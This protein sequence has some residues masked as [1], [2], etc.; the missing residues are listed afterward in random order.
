MNQ[1]EA[2]GLHPETRSA[3]SMVVPLRLRFLGQFVLCLG[4]VMCL[5]ATSAHAAAVHPFLP[6][7]SLDGSTTPAGDFDKACGTAVDS[8]GNVY[9]SSAGNSTIEVFDPE[10][11]YLT[12]IADN[13]G[14]CSLAVDGKGNVYVVDSASGNVVKYAPNGGVYPPVAGTTYSF[15]K[16]IDSSGAA[17]AVAVNRETE[18]I[19]GV[20][21]D[22]ERVYVAKG[23]RVDRYQPDGTLGELEQQELTVR[24]EGG[25]FT[26]GFESET[27]PQ[28]PFN[29]TA[30]EVKA[31]LESL[32]AVGG[33]DVAVSAESTPFGGGVRMDYTVVFTGSLAS[34]DLGQIA[35]D[36]TGLVAGAFT[37][38]S[39]FI[40]GYDGRIGEGLVD[41]ASGV[42]IWEHNDTIYVADEDGVIYILDATG[43][44]VRAEIDG[45]GSPG[46]QFTALP[47][48]AIAVDQSNGHVFVSNVQERDVVEEYEAFGHYVT[49]LDRSFQDAGPT[50]IA[51][52]PQFDEVQFVHRDATGGTF[53]LSFEGQETAPLA[54][55]ASAKVVR[56]ALEAIPS[57]GGGGV[58]VEVATSTSFYGYRVA[59]VGAVG[60]RDVPSLG[61]DGAALTG[62]DPQAG[63][64]GPSISVTTLKDGAG[65]GRVY[66]SSGAGP[67]AD[68]Y[69]FGPLPEPSRSPLAG[70]SQDGSTTPAGEFVN[71]RGAVVDSHGFLYVASPGTS[72]INVFDPNGDYVLTISDNQSP[73]SLAVD[74]VGNLYVVRDGTNESRDETVVLY[75][76]NSFPLTASTTYA[77]PKLIVSSAKEKGNDLI[78]QSVAVNPANDHLLVY[79]GGANGENRI[80]EYDSAANSSTELDDS[81]GLGLFRQSSGLDVYGANGNIY[82]TNQTVQPRFILILDPS[83]SKIVSE[84]D[85]STGPGG[86]ALLGSVSIAVDQ[87]NGHVFVA[88]LVERGVVEEYEPSGAFVGQFGSFV[89]GGTSRSD[90]AVDNTGG[91]NDGNVYVAYRAALTGFG[92]LTY[93]EPPSATT[94]QAAPLGPG[95]ARL[96]GTLDPLGVEIED[97][98]FEYVLESSF[99]ASGFTSANSVPC[100]QTATE[101]GKGTG[102]VPVHADVLGLGS[103][104]YRFRLVAANEFGADE[105]EA[106][107]FGP[108]AVSTGKAAPV[109]YTEAGLNATVDP[110]GVLTTYRFEYGTSTA[111]GQETEV[112]EASGNSPSMAHAS[113]FGLLPGETYHF[114]IVATNAFGTSEGGDQTFATL[115]KPPAQS[116]PNAQ[117]RKGLGANLPD[118]RA[119]ELVTPADT[120]GLNPFDSFSDS[121]SVY[122]ARP[123]GES[124]VF[125]M[126]GILPGT[127][128]TG[129]IDRYRSLRGASGWS[130]ELIGP[131]SEQVG[132][133][134]GAANDGISSDHDFAFWDFDA[135]EYLRA[136]NG[137][138][139]PVGLGSLGEDLRAT[140]FYIS[141][142]GTHVV[143]SSDDRLE[144][145][146]PAAGVTAIYDRRQDGPTRVVSLLPGNLAP[147]ANAKYVGASADGSAVLFATGGSTYVRLD[148]EKTLTV[149][150]DGSS[151][152]TAD[153]V[154]YAGASEDG[155]RAFY[156]KAGGLYAFETAGEGTTTQIAANGRFV[157]VSADGSHVYFTSQDQLVPEGTGGTNNLYVWDG[158]SIEF[159]AVL[160]PKDLIEFGGNVL[161]NLVTWTVGQQPK[162]SLSG[163]A[164]DP[165]RSTPDGTV[166]VFQSHASLTSYDNEG[167]SQIFRYSTSD[168]SLICI[169]CNP[170]GAQP[171]SDADL[172]DFSPGE[173]PTNATS[174]IPNVT[175]DGATVFFHS[176]DAL[177]PGDV[178]GTTDVYEWKDGQVSL[179]S[180]GHSAEK[181]FLYGMSFDGRDVFF[182]T[183]DDLTTEDLPGGTI[184]IYD[185]RVGGGFP[186]ASEFSSCRDDACQGN[187]TQPP[188]LPQATSES[189]RG[190]G[191]VTAK[192]TAKKRRVA[193]KKKAARKKKSAKRKAKTRR[194]H[195]KRRASQ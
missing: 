100:A 122:L 50:D 8:Q 129:A 171:A 178:N 110:S 38:Q 131:T 179:I 44:E 7:A 127:N 156:A 60:N 193:R 46:G 155:E 90:V 31:A 10:G 153:D 162:P 24:A 167:T 4:S 168:G 33:G 94:G 147:S 80:L 83:G 180:S 107:L 13:N 36:G 111:Y 9:V 39:T 101:I 154:V 82:V 49:E 194:K 95:E 74:S 190:S 26:L 148:N 66:V 20:I 192:K 81:I 139:E 114:R 103:D 37:L 142:G 188:T 23:N 51:I 135:V 53:K 41:K 116:C 93:G 87:S 6:G 75:K 71:A 149:A 11:E 14:P 164:T 61:A 177:V 132:G 119:Y 64:T 182:A 185:A 48:A 186:S 91:P 21:E 1:G 106:R 32:A 54:F 133:F 72:E 170:S 73:G 158:T 59:F 109:S 187:P 25:T 191:N 175:E 138:F 183:L 65:P 173:T 28:L 47:G 163:I 77:A 161:R 98:H 113:L 40:H 84:I 136:P 115:T 108:P 184:S 45:T 76:P 27:T 176:G 146:A 124:V 3:G 130:T 169:S 112:G 70:L 159:I 57:I 181:S 2:V 125:A 165:S 35:V 12:S 117:F 151:A 52:R 69:A 195:D 97:C 172:Q 92:P 19:E 102:P 140:E 157:N 15:Q 86:S 56:T 85:R 34:K 134:G 143:F 126:E 118:C 63:G 67:G 29:A 104:R 22:A 189:F 55:N 137:T 144:P 160:D 105:G 128:G 166:F 79:G 18:L 89:T 88:S 5:L 141:P 121:N 120:N 145:A 123:D 17:T 99:E 58:W 78:Y 174:R 152:T 42:D 96:N 16:T 43:T 150:D 62:N 30:E 68:L